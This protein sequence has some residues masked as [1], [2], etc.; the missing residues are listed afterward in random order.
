MDLFSPLEAKRHCNFF[1]VFMIV[2]VFFMIIF[3]PLIGYKTYCTLTSSM[4][5]KGL[6]AILSLFSILAPL[7]VL[8]LNFYLYRIFYSMCV[9][10]LKREKDPETVEHMAPFVRES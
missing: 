2:N 4:K 3:L 6:S 7:A 10:T 1:W 9:K 8:V 5:D